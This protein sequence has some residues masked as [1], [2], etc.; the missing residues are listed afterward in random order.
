MPTLVYRIA[1]DALLLVSIFFF[2]WWVSVVCMVAALIF[3][4][5]Y[6]CVI[7]ALLL[8]VLYGTGFTYTLGA[9]IATLATVV[10][11]PRLFALRS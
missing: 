6:E 5:A 9:S 4:G 11:R 3:F 2:P 1:L 7:G 10:V 8:D